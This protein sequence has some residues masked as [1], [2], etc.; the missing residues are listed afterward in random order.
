MGYKRK[1]YIQIAAAALL[2]VGI[3]VANSLLSSS[4][5]RRSLNRVDWD[6]IK[7]S[8]VHDLGQITLWDHDLTD[9]DILIARILT[10][11]QTGAT[12]NVPVVATGQAEYDESGAVVWHWINNDLESISTGYYFW[13][14]P[15]ILDFLDALVEHSIVYMN[16]QGFSSSTTVPLRIND[17]LGSAFFALNFQ[18]LGRPYVGTAIFLS[19]AIPDSDYTIILEL[20]L[21]STIG[22]SEEAMAIIYELSY[23]IGIDIAAYLP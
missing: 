14:S 16:R 18:R 3:F 9:S 23:H 7:A 1:Q 21:A 20:G 8:P 6:E 4:Q 17:E 2:I 22:W 13:S 15:D 12:Y 10:C 5:Q 19:Q 11:E